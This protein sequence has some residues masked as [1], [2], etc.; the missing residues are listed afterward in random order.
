MI[1][2]TLPIME[3][4]QGLLQSQIPC[5]D[6][7]RC[8]WS[9]SLKKGTVFARECLVPYLVVPL[10]TVSWAV[11]IMPFPSHAGRMQLCSCSVLPSLEPISLYQTTHCYR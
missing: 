10:G 4:F 9:W 8:S 1:I 5:P 7:H 3:P 6:D 2:F 11:H